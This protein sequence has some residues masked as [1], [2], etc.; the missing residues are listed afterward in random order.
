M[1]VGFSCLNEGQGEM[2]LRAEQDG[3]MDAKRDFLL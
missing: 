1:E 3:W 2:V